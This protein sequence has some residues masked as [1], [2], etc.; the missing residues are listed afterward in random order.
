MPTINGTS[1]NDSLK[2]GA[3]GGTMYGGQGNDTLTGAAGVDEIY[4]DEGN[5]LLYG[6][7]SD[8]DLMGGE[9]DDTI[10][11]GLGNDYLSGDVGNDSLYG[12]AGD[13]FISAGAGDDQA[14]GGEGADQIYADVGRDQV[15][16]DGGND[17]LYG[18]ADADSLFGG[19]GND[20][21]SGGEGD[22]LLEGG[23]GADSLYGGTQND[24]LYGEGG[25]DHLEGHEGMDSL[26][27]GDGHDDLSGGDA[28]DALYGGA[29]DDTL[30]GDEGDDLLFG[31]IGS[32]YLSGGSGHDTIYG[33]DGN[34][35]VFAD[36][37]NDLV[38]GGSGSDLLN[39]DAGNDTLEGED[40]ADELLGGSGNDELWGG[41]GND[42]LHG[43]LDDDTLYGGIGDD[44]LTGGEGNDHLTGDEG[45]DS[46]FGH[47]GND[48]LYGS[49]GRDQ[50]YGGIDQDELY[51]GDDADTLYGEEGRD[52]LFGD[53]GDDI[54]NGNDDADILYGGTG[55][56]TLFGG[57]G[58][59]SL[60]GDV[61]NDALN[62][63]AGADSL[64][65]GEGNDRFLWQGSD[66]GDDRIADFRHGN[67]GSITDGD[68]SNNDTIDLSQI[69]NASTLARYNALTG[70]N[71]G[72]PIEALNHHL[73]SDYDP[74]GD[75]AQI[76]FNG[77]D[78][79]GPSLTLEWFNP[80]SE[81]PLTPEETLVP[82][83]DG[84]VTGTAGDDLIDFTYKGDPDGDRVDDP[85]QTNPG[86]ATK[87]DHIKAGQGNDVVY[88]GYGQDTVSGGAG[89]D[90][91]YGGEGDDLLQGDAGD[92]VL[93]G[94]A[95]ADTFVGGD[96]SDR[97]VVEGADIIR[98]F[99]ATGGVGDGNQSN[100]DRVDLQKYYNE[101][102][103][104]QWNLDHPDQHYSNPLQW[105]R[106]EQAE[107][108][109]GSAGGVQILTKGDAPVDPF[110]LNFENTSVVCFTTGSRI[111]CLRGL[112]AVE[113][114][115]VGDLVLTRDAGY[116]PLRWISSQLVARGWVQALPQFVP[117]RIAAGALG[118]G[119]P[120]RDL[121]LTRQ[122]RVL[123]EADGREILIPL[124]DFDAIAGVAPLENAGAQGY[125]HLLFDDHQVIESEG[126]ACESL[127]LGPMMPKMLSL[128]ERKDLFEK[129]P[130]LVR[131]DHQ[132]AR[133][134]LRGGK[135]RKLISQIAQ[136]ADRFSAIAVPDIAYGASIAP[137]E[138]RRRHVS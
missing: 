32:D 7:G 29:G 121:M 103:L 72:S 13:D 9:G 131:K 90:Q 22:D 34:D 87:D 61:G 81:P 104:R 129:H 107:G 69:F 62:G 68:S 14:F 134:Q 79:S 45:N 67:T 39:G 8:D 110:L 117:I 38:R 15:Y 17:S 71:F 10:F 54:L 6:H 18:G 27:G 119:L 84:I 96:G 126:L 89:D 75:G 130:D 124:K 85:G 118:H 95:G 46:L 65:G 116:Q 108:V 70:S 115:A 109:L 26:W 25:D 128:A 97:F 24:S 58:N 138:L 66:R 11:G 52:T 73:R 43:E 60:F 63:G 64:T 112:V 120:I 55:Q 3:S 28:A 23:D 99:D 4:G 31:D 76:T 37:D 86:R 102:T 132:L 82:G 136:R 127:F 5:D 98:D 35:T 125:W 123:V 12:D 16:G 59:D 93:E 36:E 94:G 44:T 42:L 88:A 41:G 100:N 137:S 51:G 133:E 57:S 49:V 77:T 92:D 56:D 106:A 83:R 30:A 111:R 91:L 20:Q 50:L 47:I 21:L 1:G 78:F 53:D 113:D 114:L 33:G 80:F 19:M 105:L 48:M 40:D 135:A 2:A 122:H 74:S 101:A